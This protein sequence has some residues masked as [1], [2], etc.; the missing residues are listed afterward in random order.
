MGLLQTTEDPVLRRKTVKAIINMTHTSK[1]LMGQP[2]PRVNEKVLIEFP[3]SHYLLDGQ[4]VPQKKADSPAANKLN[5]A[6]RENA[7]RLA[8]GWWAKQLVDRDQWRARTKEGC[9][10]GANEKNGPLCSEGN[11]TDDNSNFDAGQPAWTPQERQTVID[12][13]IARL[14]MSPRFCNEKDPEKNKAPGRPLLVRGEPPA[15]TNL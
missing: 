14:A 3:S 9:C 11:G 5:F 10:A 13:R 4:A 15:D 2:N 12:R 8:K 6:A 1:T 7:N